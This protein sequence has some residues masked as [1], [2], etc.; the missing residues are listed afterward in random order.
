MPRQ[1]M[2]RRRESVSQP[3]RPAVVIKMGNAGSVQVHEKEIADK[4]LGQLLSSLTM[5][6]GQDISIT[7]ASEH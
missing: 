6:S 2:G 3:Y 4:F 7:I 5:Q 1:W